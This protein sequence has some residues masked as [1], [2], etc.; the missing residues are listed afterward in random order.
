LRVREVG[1]AL[2]SLLRLRNDPEMVTLWNSYSKEAITNE[3]SVYGSGRIQDFI[4]EGWAEYCNNP[5]G[6]RRPLS[7]EIGS[8]ILEKYRLWKGQI[9]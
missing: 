7:K 9:L 3:L 5:S 2:D 8:L 1:H 6:T 4:A